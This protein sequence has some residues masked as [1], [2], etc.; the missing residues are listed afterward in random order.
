MTVTIGPTT[1]LL[2]KF[3][4]QTN[5]ILDYDVDFT[6]WFSNRTDTPTSFTVIAEAGITIVTSARTGLIVKVLL[7]G[8]TTGTKYKVTVRLTSTAWLVKEA[9]FTVTVKDI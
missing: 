8:G 3:F 5:E 2:G 1:A 7:S 4:K 6:D 9:D